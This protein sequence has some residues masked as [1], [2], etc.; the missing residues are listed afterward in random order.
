VSDIGDKNQDQS[1]KLTTKVALGR[2]TPLESSAEETSL[3]GTEGSD[4]CNAARVRQDEGTL[5]MI[6]ELMSGAAIL[7]ALT[8]APASGEPIIF[9]YEGHITS[10]YSGLL[11]ALD[12]DARQRV[13]FSF[14]VEPVSSDPS[15]TGPTYA[16]RDV[17]ASTVTI[18]DYSI[19][20]KSGLTQISNGPVGSADYDQFYAYSNLRRSLVAFDGGW[21][22]P[23]Q[24]YLTLQ[25][26]PHVLDSGAY[27]LAAPNP[28]DFGSG[29]L[30]LN[31]TW[32][33]DPNRGVAISVSLDRAYTTSFSVPEPGTLGLMGVGAFCLTLIRR[34]RNR[35][36]VEGHSQVAAKAAARPTT[37]R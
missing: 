32:A 33:D 18:G 16:Q 3:P 17:L 28:A 19:H 23:A 13:V 9:T 15:R 5:V 37:T 31:Y 6:R 20:G 7:L 24:A 25:G 35:A 27:P 29:T 1:R 8:V 21:L 4:N 11:D 10:S 36:V 2:A 12:I 34:R 26:R 22:A 30:H 14:F